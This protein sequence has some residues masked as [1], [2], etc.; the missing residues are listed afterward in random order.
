MET[1]RSEMV[2]ES[3]CGNRLLPAFTLRYRTDMHLLF[4]GSLRAPEIS[5]VLEQGSN[6]TSG[7]S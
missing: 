4:L 5:R 7:M 1:N 3:S 2:P 6:V